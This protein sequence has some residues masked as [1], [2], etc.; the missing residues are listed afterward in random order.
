ML[1]QGK[2]SKT[3]SKS[4]F[5]LDFE[6]SPIPDIGSFLHAIALPA[7]VRVQVDACRAKG[8]GN[9]RRALFPSGRKPLPVEWRR[10]CPGPSS[11][12]P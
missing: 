3:N 1:K 9:H 8:S 12:A 11:L 4:M 5:R 2:S 7:V 6:G 10:T